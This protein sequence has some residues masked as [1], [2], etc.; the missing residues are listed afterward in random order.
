[1]TSMRART[2][3]LR[4]AVVPDWLT[5]AMPDWLTEAVRP[6]PAPVP[7][8]EMLRAAL[9]ICVP[10][11]VGIA[12]G[13]R[14]IGLLPALG[15]LLG[16]MIDTGGPY[17]VRVKRVLTAGVFGGAAGLV[18]GELIHGRGWIAVAALVV[19][20]GVSAVLS[21][22]GGTGSVTGLQ[23]LV[24]SSLGLGPFGALRPWWH[25]A[26]GFVVGVAWALLL[27]VPGWLL[28]PRSAEQRSVAAV[29]HALAGYL[30][31]IGTPHAIEARR[32]VTAALN[33]AYDTLLTA[34]STAGGRAGA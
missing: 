15:G 13:R 25:T 18:V 11:S 31:A 10:L 6:R 34:R 28:S 24:Y 17:M 30:R 2:A 20:A 32:A 19:V 1:M 23:L 27:I 8:G 12:V 14:D 3:R 26:L 21:R 29:Y 16:T 22:L 4:E 9:A 5:E 33:T 7:W